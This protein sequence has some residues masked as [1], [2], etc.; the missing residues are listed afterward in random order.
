M[1]PKVSVLLAVHDGEPY[2]HEAV[3]GV[4]KQTFREFEFLVVDDASTDNTVA[5]VDSF[6]DPRIRILRNEHNLGQVPS[7]N[8]GLLEARGEYVARI[9]ADD[10]SLPRRLERQVALLDAQ[11]EVALVGAWMSLVD[12]SGRPITRLTARM[13]DKLR[14]VVD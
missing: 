8:R 1:T 13:E 3:R 6:A 2:V 9:D 5:I 7:L 12:D 11:P 10:V 14:F 4:L